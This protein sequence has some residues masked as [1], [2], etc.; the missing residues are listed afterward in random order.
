MPPSPSVP[1]LM[2]V[3]HRRPSLRAAACSSW[4]SWQW[5]GE[6]PYAPHP[7]DGTRMSALPGQCRE[8]ASLC[9]NLGPCLRFS[10]SPSFSCTVF[11]YGQ[12]GSGKTYTLMGPL[13]QVPRWHPVIGQVLMWCDPLTSWHLLRVMPQGCWG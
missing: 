5:K 8:V 12:T 1:F 2:R 3:P 7:K 9:H 10:I 6:P 11:A 4:W 13:G